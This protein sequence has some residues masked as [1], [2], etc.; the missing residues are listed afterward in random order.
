MFEGQRPSRR[1][2]GPGSPIHPCRPSRA[3][4]VQTAEALHR[5]PPAQLA[6]VFGLLLVSFVL[7][8][9]CCEDFVHL[10]VHLQ[11]SFEC[12]DEAW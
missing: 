12:D 8:S 4:F 10:P 2:G 6:L 9:E 11:C 1:A 7:G 5:H 3:S